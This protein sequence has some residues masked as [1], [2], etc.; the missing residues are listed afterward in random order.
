MTKAAGLQRKVEYGLL[1]AFYGP[2]LTERQRILLRL[3]CDEDYSLG[4]VANQLGVSR[5]GI[6]D[7]L[8]RAYERLDELETLLGLQR[9]F[10]D[11]R[12]VMQ[13]SH[14]AIEGALTKH[15][16]LTALSEARDALDAFMK[17]EEA[18]GL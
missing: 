18:D 11:M 14:Q 10:S 16:E 7:G 9:Q 8:Q 12:R 6:S 13:L 3:Y 5:Q 4:E 17:T 15:P 1:S 2:L